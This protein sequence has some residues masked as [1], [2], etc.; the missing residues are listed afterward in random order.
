[1][2]G[3]ATAVAKVLPTPRELREELLVEFVPVAC[4]DIEV[5]A[6]VEPL[7]RPKLLVSLVV[8]AVA[9]GLGAVLRP[10]HI[11]FDVTAIVGATA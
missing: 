1:M 2:S 10:K 7:V 5:T 9:R 6:T 8:V 3:N 11:V 4:V